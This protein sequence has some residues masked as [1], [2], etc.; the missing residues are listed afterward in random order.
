V[1]YDKLGTGLSDPV[2]HVP[3]LESRVDDLR[4]V[5]DA[6]GC[7]RAA[8][9][10]LSEGGPISLLFADR[11]RSLVLYGTYACG[12]RDNDGSP[13]REKWADLI[14]RSNAPTARR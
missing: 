9:F 8:M 1:L 11:V 13:G 7:R 3:T 2:D 12:A 6:A 4:A 10:G 14:D 5:L